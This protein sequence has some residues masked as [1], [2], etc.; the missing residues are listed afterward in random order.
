MACDRGASE[1][2]GTGSGFGK[3]IF[4]HGASSSGKSTLTRALR[5]VLPVPL[6]HISIDHLRDGGDLP[7]ARI[8]SVEF[9]WSAMRGDRKAGRAEADFHHVHNGLRYDLEVGGTGDLSK[10]VAVVVA[11]WQSGPRNSS[12]SRA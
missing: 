8:T 1:R 5:A 9:A 3:T 2:G 12:L 6:W 4:L 7:S 10:S 11:G